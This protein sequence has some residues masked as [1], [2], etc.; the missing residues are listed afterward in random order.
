MG[1]GDDGRSGPSATAATATATEN[2]PV[3]FGAAASQ[4][5][6]VRPTAV[7][8]ASATRCSTIVSASSGS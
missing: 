3:A 2:R 5:Q 6:V 8:T 7:D 1:T 4:V